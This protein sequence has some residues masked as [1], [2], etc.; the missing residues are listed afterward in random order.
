[1]IKAV[2][3]YVDEKN[4]FFGA[5]ARG[6]KEEQIRVEGLCERVSIIDVNL[7]YHLT[8]Y[9]RVYEILIVSKEE[10]LKIAK[11]KEVNYCHYDQY[12]KF[13]ILKTYKK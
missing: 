7:G 2:F 12:D 3:G 6:I 4:E 11:V 1:M 5:F 13:I 9:R 8:P 10:Y